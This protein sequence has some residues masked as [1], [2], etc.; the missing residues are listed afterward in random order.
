[1]SLTRPSS[2]R[3]WPREDSSRTLVSKVGS[4]DQQHKYHL[5]LL[6][7]AHSQVP[8]LK[9]LG[10]KLGVGWDG[11]QYVNM[12]NTVTSFPSYSPGHLV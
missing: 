8:E 6:G 10:Q 3:S 4:P 11:T 2:L 5:Q 9:S 12:A 7:N 1:M